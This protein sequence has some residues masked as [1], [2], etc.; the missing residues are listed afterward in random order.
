MKFFLRRKI[1]TKAELDVSRE[2][3]LIFGNQEK[4][5]IWKSSLKVEMV[6]LGAH[7]CVAI[8]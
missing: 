8:E 3:Q 2:L 1:Q 7:F 6:T 4:W 5:K